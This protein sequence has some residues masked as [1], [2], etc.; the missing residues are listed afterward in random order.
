ML[1]SQDLHCVIVSPLRRAMQ[2]AYLL[3]KDRPDFEQINFIVNPLCRE[4]LHTAGD[5]PSTHAQT[6]SYARKL[7]PRVDTESC[8]ARFANR[9][10]FYVEDLAHE[11]AQT[12][13]LIMDQMQADPEKSPAENCFALMTQVLPDCMES[14]RNKL[15]RA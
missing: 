12:Q 11:D 2:T 9:E 14:A 3:L 8:F 5:V 7:F 13:A 4:H 15:A 6:A 10:L 1:A